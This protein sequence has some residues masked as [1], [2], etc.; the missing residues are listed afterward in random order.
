LAAAARKLRIQYPGA[1]YHVMN[2]GDRQ[3]PIFADDEDRQRFLAT[4]S[5]ACG[6]TGWQ[7]HAYC[8]MPNH[9]H[10]VVETPQPNLVAGMKWL[11]GTYTSRYNRRHQE[12]GH[13]FSGRYKSLI[14]EGSG[15][16]YLKTA[17]DYVHLN[18]ARAG[19]VKPAEALS[20]FPW[21]SYPLYLGAPGK[22]PVWLRVDRLLG[23]WG[24]PKD[25][26]AGRRVFGERME[27]RRREGRS[28]EFKPM[29]R[30]WCLGGEQFRQELLEQVEARPGP[31]H[32]GEAVQ[33]AEMV[34][35]ERLVV[36]ALARMNWSEEDLRRRRKG[37]ARKVELA[38]ELRSRT[39]MSL[40]WI[41]RLRM[42]S[43]GYL[44][45]LLQQRRIGRPGQS[46]D[47]CPL[48]R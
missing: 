41:A 14:V 5:E 7:V 39:T 1:I 46:E 37:E 19:L 33:E 31:S 44:A 43:R 23:E 16:G 36:A 21:S 9:F 45:W 28:G 4:L 17:C 10:L 8:L 34:Q 26:V 29:E 11:L 13:L 20:G 38:G 22:R 3:D 25:S 30:G 6:K 12:F 47:Q 18:P 42:G 2:R 35:A 15:N 48:T 40:G 27:W 32:F 24:I